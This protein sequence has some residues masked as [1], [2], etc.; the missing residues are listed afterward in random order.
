MTDG[1]TLNDGWSQALDDRCSQALYVMNAKQQRMTVDHGHP[2]TDDHQ[3]SIMNGHGNSIT[4]G[5]RLPITNKTSKRPKNSLK[6]VKQTT[7]SA[8]NK[9]GKYKVEGPVN[10]VV[11]S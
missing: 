8:D 10:I 5:H 9:L 1:Q 11:C 4:D 2:I 3:H 6:Q 7:N